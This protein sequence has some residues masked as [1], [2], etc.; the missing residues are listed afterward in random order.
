MIDHDLLP[1]PDL[2][3]DQMEL[4]A[5]LTKAMINDIDDA[6]LSNTSNMWR[7]VARV[8]GT[9]MSDFEPRIKGI[10]D[11]YYAGRIRALVEKGLLESQGDLKR[12]R[13]SEI[14]R[15]S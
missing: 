13:Y 11:V 2:T 10:P 8:V 7:K 3:P 14:R 1:D 5:K 15:K 4:V 12:M 9:T 6:L